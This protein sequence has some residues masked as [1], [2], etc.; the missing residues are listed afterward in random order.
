MT[1]TLPPEIESHIKGEASRRGI[2]A[3]EY[4]RQLILSQLPTSPSV[5]SVSKLFERWAGE[6]PVSD[7]DDAAIRNR[8]LEAFK[9]DMNENRA[10]S[11][12]ASSRKPFP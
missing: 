5:P 11:E 7:A 6:D 4:L 10:A 2:P 8:E 9:R 3:E 12:G 1:I